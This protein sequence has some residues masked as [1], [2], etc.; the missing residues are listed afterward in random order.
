MQPVIH[1]QTAASPCSA[2]VLQPV[3]MPTIRHSTNATGTA[4]EALVFPSGHAGGP[5]TSPAAAAAYQ[6]ILYWYPSPPVSPQNATVANGN[7]AGAAT[8]TAY[9]VQTSA[10]TSTTM[11]AFPTTVLMKGLPPNV[12]PNDVMTFL[13]GLIEVCSSAVMFLFMNC[14]KTCSLTRNKP[15]RFLI[16]SKIG[17]IAANVG[18]LMSIA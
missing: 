15:N 18:C 6:P 12:Q 2:S 10:P 14:C 13:D 11:A 7:A 4:A 3:A 16:E 5:F 8:P 9:Y 17:N 1:T